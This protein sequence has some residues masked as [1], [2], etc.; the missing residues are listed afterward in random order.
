MGYQGL[1]LLLFW[2]VLCGGWLCMHGMLFMRA[3]RQVKVEQGAPNEGCSLHRAECHACARGSAG[4]G[5]AGAPREGC[6]LHR[7][8]RH[9][10]ARGFCR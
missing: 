1:G 10:C 8:E 3:A 4:D 7:A 5:G 6:L 9:A 2:Q